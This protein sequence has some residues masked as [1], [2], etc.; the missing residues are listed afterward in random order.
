M[1]IIRKWSILLA[2]LTLIFFPQIS[3]SQSERRVAL[4]IGNSDYEHA[5]LK[6]PI[7]DANDMAAALKLCGFEV[8]KT[9][10]AD[11]K[12]MRRAIRKFGN[13][14]NKGAVGLFYY[15]GHGIQVGGE[16][17]LVPIGAKA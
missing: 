4:V 13:E 17:Y 5:P 9:I 3:L 16:N 14:I 8:M 11:R 7:N 1:R 6:N 15:A 10:N 2:A 12:T